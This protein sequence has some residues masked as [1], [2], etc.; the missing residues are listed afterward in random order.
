MATVVLKR[1]DLDR[2]FRGHNPEFLDHVRSAT[3]RGLT[4]TTRRDGSRFPEECLF[5]EMIREGRAGIGG[6][7]KTRLGQSRHERLENEPQ[8]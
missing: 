3:G 1:E 6:T 7:E 4:R 5:A 8:G 2:P